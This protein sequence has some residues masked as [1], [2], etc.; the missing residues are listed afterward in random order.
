MARTKA[1]GRKPKQKKAAN[2]GEEGE[3]ATTTKPPVS[4]D[5]THSL[6]ESKK[7]KVEEAFIEESVKHNDTDQCAATTS[8]G[9]EKS[10][11][12]DRD[13]LPGWSEELPSTAGE[14]QPKRKRKK[15]RS[16]MKNLKKD[17]RDESLK[18]KYYKEGWNQKYQRTKADQTQGDSEKSKSF[19]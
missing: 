15:T 14:Q 10:Q 5:G 4:D 1:A 7:R 6:T 2:A 11:M 17:N 19:F 16:K 9:P 8:S 13:S 12:G 3:P 18:P